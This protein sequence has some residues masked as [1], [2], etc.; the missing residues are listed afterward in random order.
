MARR[1]VTFALT[2]L[3]VCA[4]ASVLVGCDA[5]AGGSGAAT[6]SGETTTGRR[7]T[8]PAA[9]FGNKAASACEEVLENYGAQDIERNADGSY[10]VSMTDAGYERFVADDLSATEQVLDAIPGAKGYSRITH[11][12]YNEDLTEVTFTCSSGG[13]LGDAGDNAA[14]TAI[15]VCCL[16]QTIAGVSDLDCTVTFK[17][18]A[19]GVIA[20]YSAQDILSNAS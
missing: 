20:T 16:H 7:F 4:P 10:T 12:S 6:T 1:A 18:P 11:V 13:S 2:A 8:V 5:T 9:F 19:G 15:Y 3:L 14:N 17:D